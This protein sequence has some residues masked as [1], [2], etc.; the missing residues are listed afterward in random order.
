MRT[1]ILLVS[2]VTLAITLALLS[3]VTAQIADN[4]NVKVNDLWVYVEGTG[5]VGSNVSVRAGETISV[6]VTFTANES[7]DKVRVKA[8]IEGDRDVDAE[9]SEFSVEAETRYSKTLKLQLSQLKHLKVLK[10]G[11]HCQ[12]MWF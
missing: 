3:A 6:K 7:A 9:T 2:L 4:V 8:E 10:L 1:K 11:K 5:P 12:L